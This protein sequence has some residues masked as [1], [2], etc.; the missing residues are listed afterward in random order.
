MSESARSLDLKE[1]DYFRLAY[2]RWFGR[3]PHEKYLEKIFADYMFRQVAPHW[4]RH[5]NRT[6]LDMQR[7]GTL[8]PEAMGAGRY[9]DR[10]QRHPRGPLYVTVTMA[11]WL[12]LF[13]LLLD[14]SYDPG[15]SAP[16]PACAG[17][18]ASV[19]FDAWVH[20]I[21]GKENPACLGA[22]HPAIN[23]DLREA[24]SREM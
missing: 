19:F 8:D 12:V 24:A 15:N 17:S 23:S 22:F 13:S 2:R 18:G 9:R 3:Q 11:V 6:V 5:L 16:I 4:V 14:T 1:F 20:T 21:S 7:D 10:M